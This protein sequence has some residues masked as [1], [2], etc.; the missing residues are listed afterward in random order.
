MLDSNGVPVSW[1]GDMAHLMIF[2]PVNLPKHQKVDIYSGI[3]VP[4]NLKIYFGY[5]LPNGIVI[6]NGTPIEVDALM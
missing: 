3:L 6:T 2:K 1:D 5:R 4:G